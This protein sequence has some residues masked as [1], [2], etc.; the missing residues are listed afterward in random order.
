M[1]WSKG[2][3][4]RNTAGWVSDGADDTYVLG[5]S[6]YPTTR[7]GVTF[8]YPDDA[9][10]RNFGPASVPELSGT[11]FC[12]VFPTILRIDLPAAGDYILRGAFGSYYGA[13]SDA[14]I[15]IRDD[16]AP[17]MT[18]D[19]STGFSTGGTRW[20]DINDVL[21]DDAAT[22]W[23][24]TETRVFHFDSMICRVV[25]GAAPSRN[26]IVSH[27]SLEQVVSGGGAN[28]ELVKSGNPQFGTLTL[29]KT[30]V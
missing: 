13:I 16:A 11:N 25:L 30:T 20:R 9:E 22:S 1:S 3:N 23:L 4:F 17:L 15:E 2:F 7:N 10:S 28:F 14:Y 18:I 24:E 6:G 26:G 21:H 12:L 5:G 19:H 27:F 29:A 8:G